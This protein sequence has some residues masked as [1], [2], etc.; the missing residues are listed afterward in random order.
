V[1]DGFPRT[2]LQYSLLRDFLR[3]HNNDIDFVFVINI[4]EEETI[5]RLSARRMDPETG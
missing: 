5:K 4:S 2:P 3:S 1:F